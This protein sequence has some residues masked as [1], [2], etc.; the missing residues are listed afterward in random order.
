[1]NK[2]IIQINLTIRLEKIKKKLFFKKLIKNNKLEIWM[3]LNKISL[4][5]FI[6]L[7]LKILNK[8]KKI[9]IY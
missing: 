4:V 6:R 8:L 5:E 7:K 1:M 3:I 2:E 9:K